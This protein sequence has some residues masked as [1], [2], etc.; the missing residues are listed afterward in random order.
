MKDNQE[1]Q[2]KAKVFWQ[3]GLKTQS[4]IRGFEV[5]TDEPKS[6]FGTNTAPAPVEIFISSIG[7]CLLSTYAWTIMMARVSIQDCTV[8][9]KAHTDENDQKEKVSKAMITLTV[10]ADKKD[11]NKLEK[12]FDISKKICTLTNSVSFPMEISMH[13]KE[14]K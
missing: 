11:K 4:I 12:C 13:F 5:E 9:V 8:D 3:G 6:H 14:E 1:F 2:L 10:W 7:A